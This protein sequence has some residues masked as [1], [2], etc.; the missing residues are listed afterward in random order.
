MKLW[1]N[2]HTEQKKNR[3]KNFIIVTRWSLTYYFYPWMNEASDKERMRM[4][5]Y[6]KVYNSRKACTSLKCVSMKEFP[7][8]WLIIC[9]EHARK[10][11]LSAE[12][13]I[14]NCLAS[15]YFHDFVRKYMFFLHPF[16]LFLK[17][18][19]SS[20]MLLNL[21]ECFLFSYD[22]KAY[23]SNIKRLS[24]SEKERFFFMGAY[25]SKKLF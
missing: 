19:S 18:L 1:E 9:L 6:K 15:M 20:S 14:K 25:P 7:C 2:F 22:T 8:I 4:R 13:L 5:G 11:F 16:L 17:V 21:I 12:N 3:F 10:N 23:N 24:Q